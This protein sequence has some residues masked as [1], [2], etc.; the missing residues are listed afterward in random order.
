MQDVLH[1][2]ALAVI[3]ELDLQNTLADPPVGDVAAGCEES[4]EIRGCTQISSDGHR[5]DTERS[6]SKVGSH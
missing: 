4:L 5:A 2:G 1:A 3:A 6:R